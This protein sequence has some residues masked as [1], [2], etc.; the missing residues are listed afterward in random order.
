VFRQLRHGPFLARTCNNTG[1]F[2][3]ALGRPSEA[4][5]AFDEAARLHLVNG[6]RLYA[7]DSLNNCAEILIDQGRLAEGADYLAQVHSLLETV[8]NPPGWV[9][10]DY[11][12]YRTR[13]RTSIGVHPSL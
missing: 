2:L 3:A 11:E 9:L 12:H 8:L 1:I 7:A 13:L 4:Q 10:R 5:V 6:D